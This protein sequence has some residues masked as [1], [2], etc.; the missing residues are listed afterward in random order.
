MAMAQFGNTLDACEAIP[1]KVVVIREL[2]S[3]LAPALREDSH[4]CAATYYPLLRA[5]VRIAGV[6][7]VPCPVALLSGIYQQSPASEQPVDA[8][9][10]IQAGALWMI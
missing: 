7:Q 9:P 8:T 4:A 5:A 10:C 6:I 3:G 2:L 1:F